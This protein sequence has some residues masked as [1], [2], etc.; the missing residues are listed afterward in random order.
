MGYDET[1][2]KKTTT[3]VLGKTPIPLNRRPLSSL[4]LLLRM[5]VRH[6]DPPL[7]F[8]RHFHHAYSFLP[9][10]VLFRD[11]DRTLALPLGAGGFRC[12]VNRTTSSPKFAGNGVHAS[13]HSSYGEHQ[14]EEQK[15]EVTRVN[16]SDSLSS[17]L[18]SALAAT[19]NA[20]AVGEG[21]RRSYGFS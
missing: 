11:V 19:A 6:R 9:H 13:Q 21:R 8:S 16:S 1:E 3:L 20:A 15:M 14:H 5:H 7:R 17:A 12:P 2:R 4:F 10:P 18:Q